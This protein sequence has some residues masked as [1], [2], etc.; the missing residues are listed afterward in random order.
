MSGRRRCTHTFTREE[1]STSFYFA[2]PA[3]PFWANASKTDGL[4]RILSNV[5]T[6]PALGNVVYCTCESKVKG[7]N[8]GTSPLLAP[9]RLPACQPWFLS[10]PFQ[11]HLIAGDLAPPQQQL[12]LAKGSLVLLL[13]QQK[14]WGKPLLWSGAKKRQIKSRE[15][16]PPP[17]LLSPLFLSG[18][19]PGLDHH[20]QEE[21]HVD[22]LRKQPT[23]L[24]SS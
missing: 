15:V 6:M 22:H 9:S 17:L 23:S 14:V 10:Q 19:Q 11:F 12:T 20:N 1:V 3:P 16:N 4:Q 24:E 13:G 8:A 5:P 2:P 7:R 18:S 21:A